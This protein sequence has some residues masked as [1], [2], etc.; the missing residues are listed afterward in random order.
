MRFATKPAAATWKLRLKTS[1]HSC[2]RQT[3]LSYS[4]MEQP[5]PDVLEHVFSQLA[6]QGRCGCI[7]VCNS[8]SSV[9]LSCGHRSCPCVHFD[10]HTATLEH[11]T[12]SVSVISGSAAE[13]LACMTG[14]G[15]YE[16]HMTATAYFLKLKQHTSP[17]GSCTCIWPDHAG[18]Q[19]PCTLCPPPAALSQTRE[20]ADPVQPGAKPV[21]PCRKIVASGFKYRMCCRSLA[22]FHDPSDFPRQNACRISARTTYKTANCVLLSPL[23]ID[24]SKPNN[25][26][27]DS[28][29]LCRV[30]K[31]L[32]ARDCLNLAPLQPPR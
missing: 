11:M 32:N 15:L 21:P 13:L 12:S 31:A 10:P 22:R 27:L 2:R 19:D 7:I 25:I 8:K 1:G 17:A 4:E 30:G 20:R 24:V 29:I 5:L 3:Y 16:A 6:S 18:M 28:L 14:P 23:S 9:L 26:P